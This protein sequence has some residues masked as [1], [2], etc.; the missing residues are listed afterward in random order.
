VADSTKIQW[1]DATFNPWWGCERVSPA[2]AHCYADTLAKRVGRSDLWPRGATSEHEFRF[3]SEANWEKPLRWA[4]LAREGRLPNGK[5]NLDGHRP[6][7]FC[8]SMA[9]V[10]EERPELGEDRV[11]LFDLI[12]R[13]P[14]LDWL[15]LTKRPG[16][17]QHVLADHDFWL[18]VNA[19]RCASGAEILG[20]TFGL[21]AP[22]PNV[23]MGVSI[24]NSRFTWRADVLRQIPAA[25]RFISAEPLLGSL[26]PAGPNLAPTATVR[27]GDFEQ[28]AVVHSRRP[29]D[30]AGIDWVIIGGESGPRS[31]PFRLEQA[32]EIIRRCDPYE[33]VC[34]GYY[35]SGECCGDPIP[36]GEVERVPAVF[37]KQLGRHPIETGERYAAQIS[38]GVECD[39][40]FDVCPDCDADEVELR[41]RDAQGGDWD[42][43]PEDLRIREF[44]TP[45]AAAA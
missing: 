35:E 45:L 6:R 5:E 37:V 19:R 26:F 2:C 21:P 11:R 16:F 18:A 22:L 9:D 13:T 28:T 41:L 44:P 14:E 32:R 24:E 7:V 36:R 15:V 1:C 31:R 43:W 4:R 25:V 30:L 34:C 33:P 39:H 23:W 10:F 29:L 8:A 40:G 20:F 12:S 27:V 17:A 3:L 38:A 42:E